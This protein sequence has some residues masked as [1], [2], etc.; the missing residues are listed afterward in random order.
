M[1]N[2]PTAVQKI[3]FSYS[4]SDGQEHAL[5][6]AN[7]LRAAGANVWIDQLDIELGKLWDLEVEKALNTSDCVL[8][9]ATEK[10][11]TSNNVLNEV[12][13]ALDE[14]KK[15]I[16]VVFHDCRIPFQLRRLQR[17]DFTTDYNAAFQRLLK[18][19]G[20]ATSVVMTEQPNKEEAKPQ[21]DAPS[22][23]A[24]AENIAV[25]LPEEKPAP[26]TRPIQPLADVETKPP[27]ANEPTEVSSQ[28]VTN[29]PN[30]ERSNKSRKGI[31]I[32]LGAIAAA[33]IVFLLVKVFS[34]G[35]PTNK[36]DATVLSK[37]YAD[38]T[39]KDTTSAQYPTT[40]ATSPDSGTATKGNAYNAS[41][42]T[43]KQTPSSPT[44]HTV[45]TN[46]NFDKYFQEGVSHYN[47]NAYNEAIADFTSALSVK[48]DAEAFH[49]LGLCY[50]NQKDYP[51]AIVYFSKAI[52]RNPKNWLYY[53]N[54]AAANHNN[55][56][57]Q[58]A[59]DDWTQVLLLDPNNADA[60]FRRGVNKRSINDA[61][62]CDDFSA[63]AKLGN[64]N[65]KKNYDQYCGTNAQSTSG[66]TNYGL[67]QLAGKKRV[68]AAK[69]AAAKQ[70]TE[71][72]DY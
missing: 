57:Y 25:A 56:D 24:P 35:N 43:K 49:Y 38:S 14:N 66:T 41:E 59:V 46:E 62:A 15:V 4:R 5:Q 45:S 34:G 67:N 39:K 8:F 30:E 31:F 19:L 26:P 42:G 7:D 6:L 70:K 22:L 17:I 1:E 61:T 54:R 72:K 28:T 63:A 51:N 9:I 37:Q 71:Y 11:T 55:K 64:Q 44:N 50:A 12:Y 68:N 20:L 36:N 52:E 27:L 3:F 21:A 40:S 33:A 10:S 69:N 58:A 48:D 47:G 29:V 53:R 32:G 23:A 13:Y 16:P 60:Y 65:G 2:S 18:A